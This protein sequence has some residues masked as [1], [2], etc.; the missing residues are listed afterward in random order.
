MEKQPLKPYSSALKKR[1]AELAEHDMYMK[2]TPRA[3]VVGL[4]FDRLEIQRGV[5]HGSNGRLIVLCHCNCGNAKIMLY[6]SLL[7]GTRSCGCLDEE[8]RPA[9]KK[10]RIFGELLNRV[11]LNNRTAKPVAD[12]VQNPSTDTDIA[13]T[14]A[15]IAATNLHGDGND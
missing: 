11:L 2:R 12:E 3:N 7:A 10:Q 1:L 14:H 9:L 13:A 5:G 4:R 8:R 6:D 15:V